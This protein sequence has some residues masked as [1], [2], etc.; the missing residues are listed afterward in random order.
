M[1]ICKYQRHSYS[2]DLR[3]CPECKNEASKRWREVNQDQF[4]TTNKSWYAANHGRVKAWK[5]SNQDKVKS[6][7]EIYEA[8]IKSDPK[9]KAK[10]AACTRK[11][12]AAKLNRTPPWLNKEQ[13]AEIEEFYILAQELAWLNNGQVLHV[14]HIVP[15]QGEGVS[16]LHVPWNLQ[17]LPAPLNQSKGN[18]Y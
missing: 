16:G 3:R 9:H 6:Y 8:T 14:D 5:N 2:K 4:K 13:L 7:K 10:R 18:T 12:Q 17:L 1:K 11:Y 15:L